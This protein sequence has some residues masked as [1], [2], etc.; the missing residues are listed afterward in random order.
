MPMGIPVNEPLLDGNEKK[1]LNECIDTGWISSEGPFVKKFEEGFASF[2]G[3]KHGVAVA[4]GTAALEAA[5]FALGVGPGDEVI[6]PSFTIISCAV[7][8]IRLGAKPVL[9]DI[10]P[11]IWTM[12]VSQ[13]E[14][15]ITPKTKA[16]MPVHIYGHPVNMDELFRLKE[17]YGIKIIE[18]AAE[19][20][21]AEYYSEI[22]KKWLK[23]G[24]MGDI[25][26]T[27]FY[28]NK[29]ITTGEGGM[30]VSDNAE[31]AEKAASYRNLCF[32]A[33]TRF[34]HT[35]LGYNFRMTNLQA[36]V[37]V[38]Q[39]E[40]IERFIDI[41]VRLGEYYRKKISALPGVRFMPVKE[42]A[43]SVYWMY[44]VEL[45]PGAGIDAA[46]ITA[47]LRTRGIGTRPFFRGLHDQ[48]VLQEMGL[49]SNEK[50]PQTDFAYKYG[51]YLPS[52]LTLTE[53]QIDQVV[54]ILKEEI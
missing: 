47:R 21:G 6:M 19:V 24:A 35:E 15:K 13:V 46:D 41:K 5:L 42:W 49:F 48:P 53:D 51:F 2:L 54:D 40:Q 25:A 8:C 17:K 38:A 34:F 22:H 28:A 7:A 11:E 20:Q 14:S 18:D 30:V 43:K 12:D 31:Y 50:Y 1:Y 4:N 9:V 32:K 33:E 26:S 44:G 37:G 45:D 10:D 29:I 3:L 23:C 16:I 36:A 39:L 52:G 27:S